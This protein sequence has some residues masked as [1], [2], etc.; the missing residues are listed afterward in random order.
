MTWYDDKGDDDN[1]ND[2]VFSK[3]GI[4]DLNVHQ[5][6]KIHQLIKMPDISEACKTAHF[7]QLY[8]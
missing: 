7:K 4:S 6:K 5:K 2:V 1:D 8:I 3:F